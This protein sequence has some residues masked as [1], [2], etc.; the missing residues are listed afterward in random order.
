MYGPASS[1]AGARGCMQGC[2]WQ[3]YRGPT[4]FL[5]MASNQEYVA[6][7]QWRLPAVVGSGLL[8]DTSVGYAK[9]LA[10]VPGKMVPETAVAGRSSWCEVG[11][12]GHVAELNISTYIS[13]IYRKAVSLLISGSYI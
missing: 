12:R 1:T 5:V 7:S 2:I 8:D 10:G 13:V 9:N 4:S 6:S 3:P 11:S